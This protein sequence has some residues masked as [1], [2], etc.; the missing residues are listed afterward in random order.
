MTEQDPADAERDLDRLALAQR[1]KN[2][3]LLRRELD[4]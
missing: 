4:L 2:G 3:Q 1:V